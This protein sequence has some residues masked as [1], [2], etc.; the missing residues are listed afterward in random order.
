MGAICVC[1]AVVEVQQRTGL[2]QEGRSQRQRIQKVAQH[3][4][5]HCQRGAT[6]HTD[7]HLLYCEA[8]GA[9][10]AVSAG[11]AISVEHVVGV[12]ADR[13]GVATEHKYRA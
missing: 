6:A 9:A 3:R 12:A 8:V 5:Q 4:E 1:H 10:A 13:V 11:N 7:R 2:R